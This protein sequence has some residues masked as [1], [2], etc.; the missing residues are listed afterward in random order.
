MTLSRFTPAPG[1]EALEVRRIC[2]ELSRAM[3]VIAS[4]GITDFA[5][6]DRAGA[7]FLLALIRW[8]IAEESCKAH[9]WAYVLSGFNSVTSAWR[10][11]AEE[12]AMERDGEGWKLP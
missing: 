5:A 10:Q 11:A 3:T 2:D 8:E 9:R 1:A 4:N 12:Y 6:A 7:G